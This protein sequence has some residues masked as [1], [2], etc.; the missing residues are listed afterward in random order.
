MQYKELKDKKA[1]DLQKMIAEERG[2]IYD[3]RM[4]AAVTPVRQHAQFKKSKRAIARIM[5]A[6]N[7]QKDQTN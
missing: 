1:A 4:K 6:L 3:L 5:T 2:S 7:S